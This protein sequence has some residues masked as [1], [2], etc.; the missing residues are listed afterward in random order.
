M[1]KLGAILKRAGIKRLD[2]IGNGNIGQSCFFK[3]VASYDFYRLG[4]ADIGQP[5][6]TAKCACPNSV[7]RS[8]V[9]LPRYCV[10]ALPLG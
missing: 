7:Y 9:Y 2:G 1:C 8:A 4:Y 10:P 5:F 6:R 3:S